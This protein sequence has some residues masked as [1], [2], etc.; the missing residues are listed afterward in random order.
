MRVPDVTTPVGGAMGILRATVG[1]TL[2]SNFEHELTS[3][4][5]P[6]T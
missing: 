1:G 4:S 5:A 6:P 2:A 3:P